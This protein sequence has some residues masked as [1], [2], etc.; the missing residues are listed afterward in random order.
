MSRCVA[1]VLLSVA[2]FLGTPWN[3]A[4]S[5]E[6]MGFSF[7]EPVSGRHLWTDFRHRGVRHPDGW[8]VALYPDKSV[9]LLKDGKPAMK[10]DLAE[11]LTRYQGLESE[12]LIA[13][14]R[15]G[16][17]GCGGP[18][19]QNSH[20][21][22]RE[23]HGR[24]FVLAHEGTIFDFRDKLKLGRA[25]PLGINDSEFLC[26]YLVGQIEQAG[27]NEWNKEAFVWLE[28]LLQKTSALGSVTSMFSDGEYLFVYLDE[29]DAADLFYVRRAAPYGKVYF[30]NEQKEVDLGKIYPKSAKGMIFATRPLTTEQWTPLPAK[31]LMVLKQGQVVYTTSKNVF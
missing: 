18:A 6:V 23:L 10:S 15:T 17:R 3:P 24:D 28:K 9:Q 13:F 14:V 1:S 31:T 4:L 21:F 27:I 8:G 30:K 7:N 19:H 2:V 26:C 16:S 20:P 29:R 12:I 11:F 25:R 22:L 5:C